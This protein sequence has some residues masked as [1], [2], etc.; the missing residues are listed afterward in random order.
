MSIG[1]CKPDRRH[2]NR[3]HPSFLRERDKQKLIRAVLL[4]RKTHGIFTVACLKLE[5]GVDQYISHSTV[6]LCVRK[7]E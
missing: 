4:L 5:T 6:T 1:I 3:G 7:M 2:C